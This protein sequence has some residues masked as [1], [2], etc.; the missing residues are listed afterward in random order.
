MVTVSLPMVVFPGAEGTR[1]LTELSREPFGSDADGTELS[2]ADIISVED[3]E[4][5]TSGLPQA[6]KQEDMQ[7][8]NK[9]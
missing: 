9:K 6:N 3:A 4:E 1:Q 2:S 5:V 7:T 8:V